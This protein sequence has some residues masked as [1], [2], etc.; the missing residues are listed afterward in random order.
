MTMSHT[1]RLYFYNQALDESTSDQ[2]SWPGEC[3]PCDD[4]DMANLVGSLCSDG[5]HR[6]VIDIDLPARLVPSSTEGHYHLYIDTPMELPVYLAMLDAMAAA[7]VVAH[8]WV[9]HVR[10]RGMSTCRPE[11][12]KKPLPSN[13]RWQYPKSAQSEPVAEPRPR[14]PLSEAEKLLETEKP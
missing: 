6:P 8:T 3:E 9:E 5:L 1:E 4:K 14:P 2:A 11:W 13:G 7:G 10:E 12:V